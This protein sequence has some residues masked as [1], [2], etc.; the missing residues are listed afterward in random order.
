[1]STRWLWV[2]GR[3]RLIP[4]NMVTASK[5]PGIRRRMRHTLGWEI[6]NMS[7]TTVWDMS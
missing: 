7:A 3:S 2:R 4:V 6:P 1:M 5:N